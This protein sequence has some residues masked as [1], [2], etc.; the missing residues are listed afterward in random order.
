MWWI[1]AAIGAIIL[2]KN[3]MGDQMLDSGGNE[4]DPFFAWDMLIS[5]YSKSTGVPFEWIKSIMMNESALCQAKSVRRGLENPQDVQGSKSSDG[6]SWG[7]MQLTLPTARS[8][9]STVTEAGLNDPEI[10]IRIASKYLAYLGRLKNWNQEA[11]IRSYNG[12]PGYLNTV[13]G[14]RDTPIYYE[15]FLKNLAIVK[16]KNNLS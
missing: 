10:S 15:R 3:A 16:E 12:G 4:I 11:V 13:A 7:L 2:A 1:F 9:E 8:I 5:K 6:K 14:K